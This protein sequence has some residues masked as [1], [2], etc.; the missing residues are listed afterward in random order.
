MSYAAPED[1]PEEVAAFLSTSQEI[2]AEMLQNQMT[3]S[4]SRLNLSTTDMLGAMS[5]DVGDLRSTI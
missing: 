5:S 3:R 2:P 4:R 1:C